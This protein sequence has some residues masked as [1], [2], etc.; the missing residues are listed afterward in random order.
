MYTVNIDVAGYKPQLETYASLK[1]VSNR[2]KQFV[3][4]SGMRSSQM[5]RNF[6]KVRENGKMKYRVSYNGRVWNLKGN[7]IK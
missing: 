5:G 2:I 7:E 4:Q 3:R 6:G 1:S